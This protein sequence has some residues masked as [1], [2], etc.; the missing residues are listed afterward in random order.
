MKRSTSIRCL[1]LPTIAGLALSLA[2]CAPG[3]VE[4]AA[5]ANAVSRTP[6]PAQVDAFIA[7]GPEPSL[8]ALRPLDYWLHYKLMQA[9]GIEAALG[10]EER[11][12]AALKA[13]AEDYERK[14][15]GTQADMPRM[16]PAAFTGE[17]MSSGL[18][19]LGLGMFGGLMTGGMMAG[20][21]SDMSDER[22]AELVKEGPIKLGDKQ[23]SMSMQVGEDG[24]LTQ[25]F[26]YEGKVD[27]GLTGKIKVTTR[28]E[29]CPDA[30][31]K[32]TVESDVDSS[33]RVSGKAGTGGYVRSHFVYERWLDDD[34]KL[35][36]SPEGSSSNMRIDM[37][38]F[39][40]YESQHVELTAGWERGGKEIFENRG[41][42]G[43][44]IFRMDEVERTQKLVQGAQ[45]LQT[46]M[47]EAMLRGLG[48]QRSP[49]ESGRCVTLEPTTAP[50][51]RSGVKP[52]ASFAVSAQPRARSDGAPAGGT[53][54]ATLSGGSSLTQ[55][56]A[57]V[58]ADAQYTYVAPAERDMVASI[59]FEARSKR[60]V[61]R[62]SLAFD[63]KEVQAYLA[64]GGLDDFH[65]VGV[66]CDLGKPF[67]ISGGGNTVT[68][69]P[70]GDK[71]GTYTYAGNMGGIGVYGDGTWRATADA[72]G[73]TL[74]GTGNGCVKT[75]MGT[76][77]ANDT[78]RYT[79]KPMAACPEG[80]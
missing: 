42:G 25:S 8:Q 33:V 80:Q 79:L 68:F 78:E 66:I 53:V 55:D 35:I 14:V 7:E 5:E 40:N 23:G 10:G 76:R 61:G 50:A 2:S 16:I 11:S 24:S 58:A 9:T 27:E 71:S 69:T 38:G 60:G 15:R 18:M 51:K 57:K 47:A 74:T 4:P 6:T 30:S 29:A 13:L 46:L 45:L 65:G 34:A 41:E 26:E 72:H 22:L 1:L 3:D 21:I 17:G 70:T 48:A 75:P 43:Y 67:T 77:C 59:A 52:S 63:T 54:R 39:E 32:L 36:D 20:A 73:G 12:V 64:E 19:G 62:A 44:S 49:W 56:G 28:M 37:G 31:G